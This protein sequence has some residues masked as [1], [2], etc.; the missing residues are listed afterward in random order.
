MDIIN[1]L[2]FQLITFF[3][4]GLAI[5]YFCNKLSD[6][7]EYI[8]ATFGLGAAFG[9]TLMLAVVTNLPEVAIA[10]SGAIKGNYDLIAGNL[11]GGIAIQTMLLIIY[12]YTNKD[13]RPLSTLISSKTGIFQGF[14]LII[15][16]SLCLFGGLYKEK[17][18]P[19][20]AGISVWIVLIIWMG[21]LLYLKKFQ[22][23]TPIESKANNATFTKKSSL[24]WLA[25]ISIAVLF[26]GVLLE[27][28]SDII[29]NH[30]NLSGVFFGATVLALVTSLPEISS[31]L[32]F[33]KNKDYEPIISDI[34]GGNG[35]LPVLF[36]P[37]S[38]IAGKNIIQE[39]GEDN[40]FLAFLS[41][42]LTAIF[43]IGMWR[44][45][46]KKIGKLGWDNWLMLAIGVI[47]FTILYFI[48]H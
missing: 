22:Q 28:S 20:G 29:A 39:A 17:V 37:A 2:P 14:S 16:L 23:K 12:D 1:S 42:L 24:I 21:S 13:S 5:W 36:L 31:G 6:V 25:S 33:V 32:E 38:I 35:F 34:F 44:K 3:I 43:I 10:I 8:D 7:V 11:L 41:I 27:H 26:F 46:S 19:L 15:I 9:G 45:T 30:F 4:S 40:N 47:G 18:A 48:S